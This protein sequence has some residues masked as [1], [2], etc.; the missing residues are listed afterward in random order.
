MVP[1]CQSTHA[2]GLGCCA[3]ETQYLPELWTTIK[4]STHEHSAESF[5]RWLKDDNFFTRR[6]ARTRDA[7][8][9]EPCDLL[10]AIIREDQGELV[11]HVAGCHDALR[12]TTR[13]SPFSHWK[14]LQELYK[15]SATAVNMGNHS[16]TR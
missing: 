2:S 14:L 16:R 6:D 13:Q 12:A 9:L 1:A 8:A 3:V 7:T 4:R 15:G 11:T 5:L 10:D